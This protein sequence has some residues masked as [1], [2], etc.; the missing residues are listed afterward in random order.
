MAQ[1]SSISATASIF[2]QG[3]G[4]VARRHFTNAL[5]LRT[6]DLSGF[7]QQYA[8]ARARETVKQPSQS[9]LRL[10]GGDLGSAALGHGQT[11]TESVA[12]PKRVHRPRGRAAGFLGHGFRAQYAHAREGG[13]PKSATH[14]EAI[15]M[16]LE[17]QVR[18]DGSP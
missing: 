16:T 8:Q 2:P 17:T 12:A 7:R 6:S 18:K 14:R 10:A 15:S 5:T 11:V 9:I 3:G 4:H 13:G 1:R